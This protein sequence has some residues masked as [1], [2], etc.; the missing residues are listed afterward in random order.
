MLHD[1]AAP[2]DP[3]LYRYKSERSMLLR[4][5]RVIRTWAAFDAEEPS[6]VALLPDDVVKLCDGVLAMLRPGDDDEE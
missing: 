3:D 2:V 1:N 5:V 4:A 6:R